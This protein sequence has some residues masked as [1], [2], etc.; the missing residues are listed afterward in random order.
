VQVGRVRNLFYRFWPRLYVA[1]SPNTA[2]AAD[3]RYNFYRGTEFFEYSHLQVGPPA[4][5]VAST[6]TRI[7]TH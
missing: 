1:R 4:S 6:Q 7:V 2:T 5:R 3:V